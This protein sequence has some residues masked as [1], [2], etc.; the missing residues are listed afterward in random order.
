MANI[1]IISSEFLPMQSSGINRISF[2]KRFLESQGHH[3]SVLTTSSEAQGI[4]R[5]T[6]FDTSNNIFRAYSL[7][8]F[9][10]RLLSSRKLPIYPKFAYTG[11][12]ATWQFSA[13]TKGKKLVKELGIDCIF[14]S[15]PDFASMDVATRIAKATSTRLDIDFRDPPYWFFSEPAKGACLSTCKKIVKSAMAACNNIYTSTEQS[16][17]TLKAYYNLTKSIVV[18]GNGY[19][20]TI[21]DN[22]PLRSKPNREHIEIVHIGSFYPEGRDIMPLIKELEHIAITEQKH[23]TLRLI[24][25][26]PSQK[27]IHQFAHIAET[28]TISIEDPLPAKEALIEANNADILLLIQGPTFNKQIPAKTYEYIA[29]NNTILAVIGLNGATQNLLEH[30]PENVN[31]ADY[32]DRGSIRETLLRAITH[33][34]KIID[35]NNLSRQEQVKLLTGFFE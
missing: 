32:E 14:V 23:F 31:I 1:L 3:I 15:F 9:H 4:V 26:P 11:K 8:K 28:I 20:K 18:I 25:D 24:G 34:P 10:R 33:Q 30:Y 19:D 27:A 21:I 5:N 6:Q 13:I 29:L 2:M 7:S 16:K 22:L 12:Y 35:T 17:S